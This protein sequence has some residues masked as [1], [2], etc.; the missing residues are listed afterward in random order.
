MDIHLQQLRDKRE[1]T[2]VSTCTYFCSKRGRASV[3]SVIQ[4]D[5][6][7]IWDVIN[8]RRREAASTKRFS[9]YKRWNSRYFPI[10]RREP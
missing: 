9:P 1:D 7:A 5:R 3:S 8:E 2:V 10:G 6:G 4:K